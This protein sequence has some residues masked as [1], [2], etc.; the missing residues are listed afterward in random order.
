MYTNTVEFGGNLKD[1]LHNEFKSSK[2]VT[3]ATGYISTD[4][5]SDFGNEFIRI[6]KAGG[7]SKLLLG[8]AFYEGL[9]KSQLSILNSLNRD[10]TSINSNSGVFV[11]YS[12]R[13]HGKVYWFEKESV[14]NIFVGSSN[15]SNSG[16]AGN[17]ECT[18]SVKDTDTQNKIKDFLNY[19]LLAENAVIIEKADIVVPGTRNYKKVV[20]NDL[21]RDLKRYNPKTIDI[22]KLPK[23]E[24]P[25]E[26]V[27]EKEKSSLNVYFGKGRWSRKTGIVK[28]RP[29]YEIELIANKEINTHPL[30]PKGDFDAYTDDG[31]IIPMRTQGDYNK[32]IRSRNKLEIFGMW[33]KGKL[34]QSGAL[35]PLTPVT[36]DTLLEYG[37]N[38]I[39]F[40]KIEDGKYFMKF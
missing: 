36:N 9:K 14:E 40:Y 31:Y 35:M 39:E 24:Y 10:L 23:F 11:S 29:W 26:R 12:R 33:L 16:I 38:K 18:V 17:V 37:N 20:S 32:N 21:M 19:L 22:S 1:V 3:I 34:Q 13:Y 30:Y 8:M 6:A 5:I 27:A 7:A 28:P 4:I 2:A 25:L 15:F